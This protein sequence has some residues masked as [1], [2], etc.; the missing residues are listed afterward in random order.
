M[1]KIKGLVKDYDTQGKIVHASRNISYEFESKG[2]YF[3]LGKSGCG[4]TTLLNV[5]AGLDSY[6]SGEVIVDNYNLCDAKEKELDEYRNIHI[7][8]VFQDF[9]L[10]SDMNVYDNLR[11]VLELQS[12][13]H[14]KCKAKIDKEGEKIRDILASVGLEGYEKRK[15]YELSGGERQRIAIARCLLKEPNIIFADEPTGNLDKAS[16]E[17]IM[18]LLEKISKDRLVV[19]VSHDREAALKYGDKVINMSD[20]EI[21]DDMELDKEDCLYTFNIEKK[22]G[23]STKYEKVSIEQMLNVVG[24]YIRDSVSED[25]LVIKYLKTDK[26]EK[27]SVKE[28]EQKKDAKETE[29]CELSR[30]Y[31]WKLSYEFIKKRKKRFVFTAVLLALTCILLYFSMYVSFYDKNELVVKYI[32]ENNVNILPAYYKCNYED[33]FFNLVEKDVTKGKVFL[34]KTTSGLSEYISANRV[35]YDQILENGEYVVY[36]GTIVFVSEERSY[37]VLSEGRIPDLYNEI[38]V[39]DYVADTLRIKIG[40]VI[41]YDTE[42]FKV[43]GIFETDYRE[44]GVVSK[45]NYGYS[46]EF[47]DFNCVYKY[48]AIYMKDDYLEELRDR[49]TSLEIKAADYMIRRYETQYLESFLGVS[50]ISNVD[51]AELMKGRMPEKDNEILISQGFAEE[52]GLLENWTQGKTYEFMDIHS[53][54]YENAY[55][56][57]SN[58]YEYFPEGIKVVGIV[59]Y[60]QEEVQYDIYINENKWDEIIDDYYN[61]YYGDYLLILDTNQSEKFV[62][63]ADESG[64][65]FSEPAIESI[66]SFNGL[67]DNIKPILYVILVI[68]MAINFIMLGTFISIS[69]NENKKS[70]GILR[71]LGVDMKTCTQIFTLEFVTIFLISII[72]AGIAVICIT[73]MA[74][75]LYMEGL[76]EVRYCIVDKSY[77]VFMIMALIEMFI[78]VLAIRVPIT[79]LSKKK[80]VEIIRGI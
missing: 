24:K 15:I 30:A 25:E 79:K 19:V 8:I 44:E 36:N 80:P 74:N 29:T 53:D 22:Q 71:S 68:S 73:D 75:N 66:V 63:K 16:G 11:I 70:I 12:T 17:S 60:S 4:K 77:P 45:L 52:Y 51:N 28:N 41:D 62:E 40:S 21:I 20:G 54:V 56:D 64:I 39:S 14:N 34:K 32:A 55:S 3:I 26:K 78:N 18:D 58:M 38:V 59:A 23:E 61:Y 31:R 50:V 33:D 6:D 13:Q 2:L 72:L 49:K 48:F 57:M 76:K 7:G 69:I 46:G 10:L 65:L 35:I 67:I 27:K 1:I 42:Q 37:P 9:N 5:L 43:V 47:F